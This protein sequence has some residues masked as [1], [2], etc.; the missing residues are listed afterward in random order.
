MERDLSVIRRKRAMRE[1]VKIPS[2][3]PS[4]I[5]V[6]GEKEE[7]GIQNAE[8]DT[9]FDLPMIDSDTQPARLQ[10]ATNEAPPQAL[11][12]APGDQTTIA[13][14][15]MPP[16]VRDSGGLASNISSEAKPD[17]KAALDTIENTTQGVIS[18]MEDIIASNDEV[19]Q[20]LETTEGDFD[21][22]SMFN[23]A[24]LTVADGAMN[25]DVDFSTTGQE[26]GQAS[27][28]LADNAFENI[29]LAG[30]GPA[31]TAPT[32]NED[33]TGL[34]DDVFT[35]AADT[36]NSNA[37]P[38]TTAP[39]ATKAA[40]GLAQAPL[41][42]AASGSA[43][44]QFDDLFGTDTFDLGGSDEVIGGDGNLAEFDFDEEWLKM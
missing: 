40:E 3:A 10:D 16:D 44:S 36:T 39:N 11:Q 6:P 21:F 31:N 41:Q 4:P 5:E 30:T 2:M 26:A 43:P 18:K 25:F 33:I 8:I 24:D 20:H 12:Q 42:P 9:A 7:Q 32:V 19:N 1:G 34:L 37:E 13:E 22:D 15:G 17:D 23:D 28:I 14:Q 29:A 35:Q 38:V 27:D